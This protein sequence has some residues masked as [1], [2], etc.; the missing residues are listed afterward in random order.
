M[1][2]EQTLVTSFPALECDK[3][4]NGEEALK[5]MRANQADEDAAKYILI[6]M[7]CNMPVMDGFEATKKIRE[8]Y[9]SRA[10]PIVA[11]TAFT[12]EETKRR[13]FQSGMV[14]YL[15]KPLELNKFR[16]ILSNI[17]L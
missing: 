11:L 5:Q 16:E 4:F 17:S 3:A 8:K 1:V 6:L 7:D 12:T 14:G 2:I 15:T 13:C 10:P 9:G